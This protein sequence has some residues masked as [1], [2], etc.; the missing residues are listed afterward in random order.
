MNKH[1]KVTA[2]KERGRERYLLILLIFLVSE[3]GKA[4]LV[5]VI[6]SNNILNN[7]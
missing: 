1:T 3:K 6:F 2:F 7:G 4:L 5:L